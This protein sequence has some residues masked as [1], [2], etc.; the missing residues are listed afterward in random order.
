MKNKGYLD[1]KIGDI[2]V[3]YDE[4][5]RDLNVH[6]LKVES[7]EEDKEYVTKTNPNGRVLYGTDME[8]EGW[9]DDYITMVHEG[10]FI[11]IASEKD[12]EYLGE[13]D[14]AGN[15]EL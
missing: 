4:Y 9:E 15:V 6:F 11:R 14:T 13:I 5:S 1:I 8:E 12:L 2:V 7:I 10:S 3:A